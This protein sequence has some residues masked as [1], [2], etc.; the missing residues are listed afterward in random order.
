M[1][2]PIKIKLNQI[3]KIPEIIPISDKCQSPYSFASGSNVS[4]AMYIMIPAT[5]AI[6]APIRTCGSNMLNKNIPTIAPI[7]SVIPES[8]A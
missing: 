5:A 8:A 3:N 4:K 1:L 7:G 2:Y 6:K